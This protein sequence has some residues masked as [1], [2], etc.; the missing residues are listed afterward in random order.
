MFIFNSANAVLLLN[1]IIAILSSTYAFFE[2]KKI[3]LYY[4]V[5]VGRFAVMEFDDRFGSCACAQ[6]PLNLMTFPLQWV[7]TLPNLSDGFLR[8]YNEFLCYMLYFPLS[9]FFT[10]G[11]AVVA[12]TMAPITYLLTTYGLMRRICESHE[13]V[14]GE[15]PCERFTTFLKFLIFGPIIVVIMVPVDCFKFY[16][17]LFTKPIIDPETEKVSITEE[18]LD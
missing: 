2:D 5:L 17:N 4:E 1:L 6:A 14:E 12:V 15:D 16:Y 18:C 11:F 7:V 10:G 3:G 13:P 8:G 9:V